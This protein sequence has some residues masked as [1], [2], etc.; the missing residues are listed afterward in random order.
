MSVVKDVQASQAK[1]ERWWD[2]SAFQDNLVALIVQDHQT[3]RNCGSILS[4]EDFRPPKGATD[5]RARW[6]VAERAL[7]F[8]AKHRE[9]LGKLVRADVLSYANQLSFGQAQITELKEYLKKLAA[10]KPVAPDALVEKVVAFKGQMFK[11]AAIEEMVDLQATGLLTDEKWREISKR[12]LSAQ[13]GYVKTTSYLESM[14]TRIERRKNAGKF[15]RIP[16]T[17]IDPLDILVHTVGPKQVGLVI[18]PYKRGK[19]LFLL[20]LT[21]AFARQRFTHLH[22]TLE[23]SQD[24]VEDRL[25]AL[26]TNIP[27]KRLVE[28]P[29]AVTQRFARFRSMIRSQI[30]IYDGTEGG[31]TVARLEQVLDELRMQGIIVTS[32]TVDY[33]EKIKPARNQ[34]EK[35]FEFDEIY[36]DL[37]NLAARRNLILWIAAQTQRDT[38]HMKILSGD[39]VAEDLGKVRKVTCAISMGKGD[40]TDESI[41]LWVAAHKTDR[42]EVGC[43]IVPDLERMMIYDED[44]TRKAARNN[45]AG[46]V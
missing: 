44:A 41:Y 26:A 28:Y 2:D 33:D 27:L 11:T 45:A 22:V 19:S 42:M 6:I 18:A 12:A 40:W 20:W 13:N 32:M 17:F 16:F 34:K 36:S 30:H 31:V 46:N 3:L 37:C 15:G 24:I 5:G 38:R 23:D 4:P 35:R 21:T 14:E 9:P 39:K 8:F 1:N 10:L 7:E 29:K 25:D 43:E